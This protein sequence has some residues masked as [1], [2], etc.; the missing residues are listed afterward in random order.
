MSPPKITKVTLKDFE[1]ELV[2]G[3]QVVTKRHARS[4]VE[5]DYFN[6]EKSKETLEEIRSKSDGMG[7]TYRKGFWYIYFP[8]LNKEVGAFSSVKK[9]KDWA[10]KFLGV[11]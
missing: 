3:S 11:S 7:Y 8:K 10:E 2:K 9:A 4:T 6:V 1:E 5:Q